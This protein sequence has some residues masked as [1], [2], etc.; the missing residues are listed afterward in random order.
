MMNKG[1]N[2]EV[3]FT[4]GKGLKVKGNILKIEYFVRGKTEDGNKIETTIEDVSDDFRPIDKTKILIGD[5]ESSKEIQEM[6]F[7]LGYDWLDAEKYTTYYRIPEKEKWI[8]IHEDNT[9]SLDD[10]EGYKEIT[11]DDL[12][13]LL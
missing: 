13:R 3:E 8:S 12:R 5:E 11:K 2:D 10:M 6:L 1:L 7:E 4:L 9:I